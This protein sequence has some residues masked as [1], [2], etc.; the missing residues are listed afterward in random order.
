MTMIATGL[1]L[2]AKSSDQRSAGYFGTNWMSQ[3]KDI[4][5]HL[6]QLFSNLARHLVGD[7][8]QDERVARNYLFLLAKFSSLAMVPPNTSSLTQ[9]THQSTSIPTTLSVKLSWLLFD[10]ALLL[11]WILFFMSAVFSPRCL[12]MMALESSIRSPALCSSSNFNK[13]IQF[14]HTW[15]G[16]VGLSKVWSSR[17]QPRAGR[18]GGIR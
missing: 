8:F 9:Q 11:T 12:A 5:F 14:D 10:Y 1:G 13:Q 6:V 15:S 3:D 7:N 16:G 4:T 18:R 17:E 2:L